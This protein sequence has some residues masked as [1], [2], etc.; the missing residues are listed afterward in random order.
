MI[1]FKYK[2]KMTTVEKQ[3]FS[4]ANV[5]HFVH[6]PTLTL[7]LAFQ[8]QSY[9]ISDLLIEDRFA[10]FGFLSKAIALSPIH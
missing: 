7:I 4:P 2:T 8:T 6:F 10:A 5:L 3:L 9:I 1:V